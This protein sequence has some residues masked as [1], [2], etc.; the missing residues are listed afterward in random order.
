MSN[1][2]DKIRVIDRMQLSEENYFQ[3]LLEQAHRKG[4]VGDGDIERIQYDCLKLLARKVER[5][6]SGDSSSIR[7][8]KAQ[9]IMASLL[10]TLGLWLKTYPNPDDAITVL[11]SE[12]ID[13]IYQKGRKRI[14]LSQSYPKIKWD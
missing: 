13:E 14:A 2:I 3:S 9:D 7:V 1:G 12:P 8:E 11:Q 5:Y 10:F 4:L 6:N